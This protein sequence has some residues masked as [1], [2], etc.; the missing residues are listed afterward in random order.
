MKL[1]ELSPRWAA[2]NG[3]R[4]HVNFLCPTCK[5]HMIAVPIP[6]ATGVVWNMTGDSFEN[7]TLT[8]SILHKTYY[9]DGMAK[10]PRF[11]ETHFFITNGEIQI[12]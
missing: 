11:C 12:V 2:T 4:D 6:P 1:T 9:A 7:L 10:P 5:Q 8:P 3:V